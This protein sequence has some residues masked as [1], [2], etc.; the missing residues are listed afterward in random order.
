MTLVMSPSACSGSSSKGATASTRPR[1]LMQS[2]L[3]CQSTDESHCMTCLGKT[4]PNAWQSP[5]QT[6]TWQIHPYQLQ[7]Q[8]SLS[9]KALNGSHCNTLQLK[10][11]RQQHI[12][13]RYIKGLVEPKLEKMPNMYKPWRDHKAESAKVHSIEL[14]YLGEVTPWMR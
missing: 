8:S 14:T 4:W 7:Q 5:I 9:S 6:V 1:T 13:K 3:M 11:A 2:M 10:I 12:R